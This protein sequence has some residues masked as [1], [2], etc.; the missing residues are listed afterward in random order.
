VEKICS[1]LGIFLPSFTNFLPDDSYEP[2]HTCL[3][4]DLFAGMASF[5]TVYLLKQYH[6]S[7]GCPT[8]RLGSNNLPYT[9][10]PIVSS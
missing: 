10:H 6:R 2:V 7:I 9:E 8:R 5:C 3:E 1:L 4:S